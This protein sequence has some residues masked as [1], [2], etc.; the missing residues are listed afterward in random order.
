MESCEFVRTEM[1]HLMLSRFAVAFAFTATA[2]SAPAPDFN[3][4]QAARFAALALDCVHK[5]DLSRLGPVLVREL[6]DDRVRRASLR[7]GDVPT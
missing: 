6:R 5:A 2:M 3:Q 7:F 4:D 1:R